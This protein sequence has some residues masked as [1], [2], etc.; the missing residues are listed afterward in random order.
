MTSPFW[1]PPEPS[2]AR[3]RVLDA[4]LAH[5]PFDGWSDKA[6][7]AAAADLGIE[8]DAARIASRASALAS[9]RVRNTAAMRWRMPSAVRSSCAAASAIRLSARAEW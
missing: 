3:D 8:P 7:A 2:E 6:L 5:A 1:R 4:V 9:K